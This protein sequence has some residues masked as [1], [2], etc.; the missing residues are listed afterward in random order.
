MIVPR[1]VQ[2]LRRWARLFW[3]A[4]AARG[5]LRGAKNIIQD[6]LTT[7]TASIINMILSSFSYWWSHI[8]PSMSRTHFAFSWCGLL[9][10]NN[11][12]TSRKMKDA[13]SRSGQVSRAVFH[14]A[15]SAP[16]MGMPRE[17]LSPISTQSSLMGPS[18]ERTVAKQLWLRF[19]C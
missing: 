8:S 6:E 18:S 1:L 19:C 10:L 15:A 2:H 16:F 4:F 17:G 5:V 9:A 12:A 7:V 14:V 3:S 11:S 13:S